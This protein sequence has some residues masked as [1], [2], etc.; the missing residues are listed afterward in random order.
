MSRAKAIILFDHQRT[1]LLGLETKKIM[2]NSNN[3]I[4]VFLLFIIPSVLSIQCYKCMGTYFP[5]DNTTESTLEYCNGDLP[6][7]KMKCIHVAYCVYSTGE[8]GA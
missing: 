7:E 1:L 2:G 5:M 3:L 4:T 8:M 6:F